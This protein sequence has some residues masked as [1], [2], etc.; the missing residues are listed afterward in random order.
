M[1]RTGILDQVNVLISSQVD[2]FKFSSLRELNEPSA[3]LNNMKHEAF[4][5]NCNL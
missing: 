2:I 1:K 3:T 5:G 4:D